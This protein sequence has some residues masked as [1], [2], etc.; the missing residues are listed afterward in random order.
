VSKTQSV[1]HTPYAVLDIYVALDI[2]DRFPPGAEYGQKLSQ[3]LRD[4][5]ETRIVRSR[6]ELTIT[7][8]DQRTADLLRY[9]VAAPL[10]RVRRWRQTADGTVVYAGIVLYRSDLFVWDATHEEAGAYHYA[11]HVVP[12]IR[13][14]E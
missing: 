9:P 10:V 1:G 4:D 6:Q 7:H 5:A 14:V 2:F 8:S 3:L 12:E 13:P 11:T